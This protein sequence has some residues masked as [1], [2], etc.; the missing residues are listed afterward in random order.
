MAKK[1]LED[2]LA[3]DSADVANMFGKKKT[4]AE[5]PRRIPWNRWRSA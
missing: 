5:S 3:R 1:A 2:V 4:E